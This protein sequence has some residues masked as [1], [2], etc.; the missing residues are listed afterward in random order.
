M[1]ITQVPAAQTGSMTLLSTTTLSGSAVNLT[2]IPQTYKNL[3]LVIQNFLPSGDGQYANMRFNNDS[4]TRYARAVA[5]TGLDVVS[6][7]GAAFFY[8]ASSND[9][10][11]A[12]GI[13]IIDIFDYR[14]TATW[15]FAHMRSVGND[16]STPTSASFS[17]TFNAYNQTGAITQ[18]NLFPNSGTFTSGTVLLY[19]VN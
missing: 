12:N 16:L 10:A 8:A 4:N 9:N 15:K 2:S 7:F 18:I 17:G 3:Q 6:T 19:G 5:S 13:S 1:T 11:T 14:N